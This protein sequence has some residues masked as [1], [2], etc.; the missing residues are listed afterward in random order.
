M[1]I[2]NS[3]GQTTKRFPTKSELAE[4]VNAALRETHK[5]HVEGIPEAVAEIKVDGDARKGLFIV[6]E[7]GEGSGKTTQAEKLADAFFNL[8]IPNML[9]REPGVTNLGRELRRILL[10]PRHES[11]SKK[12]EALLFAADRAEHVEKI[13]RPA[14]ERGMVVIC[15]RY[16]ASTMAYQ[17][18]AGGL[19]IDAIREMSNWASSGLYP[20]VT[21]FLDVD[22]K[23]GLGRVK[24]EDKNRFEEKPIEYHEKVREGFREESNNSWVHV[25]ASNQTYQVHAHIYSHA[26][27][28]YRRLMTP[29]NVCHEPAAAAPV[30]PTCHIDLVQNPA[31]STESFCVQGHGRMVFLKPGEI[32]DNIKPNEVPTCSDCHLPLEKHNVLPDLMV[33]GN[34]YCHEYG[35]SIRSEVKS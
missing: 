8:G 20:D 6:L 13:I 3:T 7:G 17:A 5:L 10:D 24:D 22:P 2:E 31:E 21:Y 18:Y 33:C 14:L 29:P 4:R 16:I 32:V 27:D 28:L 25:N 11:F 23:V 34:R 1:D 15:D 12:A 19:E 26:I 35:V 30:C 9:T